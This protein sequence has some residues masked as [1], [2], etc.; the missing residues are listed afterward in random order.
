MVGLS[1]CYDKLSPEDAAKVVL[2]NPDKRER[3]LVNSEFGWGGEGYFSVPRSVLAMR[4]MGL[5]RDE[6]EQVTWENPKKFFKLEIV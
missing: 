4:R 5:K 3:L 2:E 1:I 6:I